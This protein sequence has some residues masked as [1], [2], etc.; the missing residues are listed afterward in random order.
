MF[1]PRSLTEELEARL[2]D[3]A[4]VVLLGPRQVGKTTLAR[5]VADAWPHGSV[6]LDLENPAHRRRLSDPGAYLRAQA[7]KLVLIDEAQRDPALFEVLRGIIDEN[8]RAGH[9]TGQFLLLGS[10]SLSLVG[11]TE[12]LAGRVSYLELTGVLPNEAASAQVEADQLWVRGGYPDSLLAP[13]ASTS[14]R[15]REDL[16]RSYLERDIPF[17]APRIPAETLR[18][19]WTMVAYQSGSLLNAS[20]L[21]QALAV[22]GQTVDRYL[23]LLADL[24]LVRRLPSW[25]VNV[26]KRVTKAPK[27]LVRDSGLLHALLGLAT[28]DEVLS[29]PVAGH[30][31][32]SF[33]VET[34]ISSVGQSYRPHHYRTAKGDEINL[35]LERGGKPS[36]A[37]EIKRSTAPTVSS[38]LLRA[39]DDLGAPDTYLVHPNTEEGE[40]RSHDVTVIGLTELV[41]RLRDL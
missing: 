11:L 41:E 4:A 26:G 38:S 7:P 25:H 33:A 6:Y 37:I 40:Y 8:R 29:H 13:D 23:D 39:R 10:A 22:K 30:S 31:Y 24:Y 5:E 19:L 9:R 28:I 36:I 27:I 32:E 35:V 16:I 14:L 20:S 21:G 34:L 3:S 17:F 15:W 1:L 18:R 12:S 2:A